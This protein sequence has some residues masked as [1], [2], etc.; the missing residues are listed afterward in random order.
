MTDEISVELKNM[1]FWDVVLCGFT[2]SRRFGGTCRLYLQRKQTTLER[3]SVGH[4]L[5]VAI[6]CY[7]YSSEARKAQSRAVE[8][9]VA[10][11]VE[12]LLAGSVLEVPVHTAP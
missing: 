4:L 6:R 1:V 9:S 12:V 8:S 2:I 3:K 10:V 7:H 11:S 5:S